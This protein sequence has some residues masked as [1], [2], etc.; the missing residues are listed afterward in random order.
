MSSAQIQIE[1]GVA[2]GELLISLERGQLT[3]AA[4]LEKLSTKEETEF[5]YLMLKDIEDDAIRTPLPYLT[6]IPEAWDKYCVTAGSLVIS[7]SAP[8]KIAIIPDL[9]GQKVLIPMIPM[10][11]QE[12]VAEK[13]TSLRRQLASLKRQER[14]LEGKIASLIEEVN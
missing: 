14:E 5:Q 9:K 7:R 6:D 8:I 1:N 10:E 4:K 3:P 2:L 11:A 12:S 13:Y